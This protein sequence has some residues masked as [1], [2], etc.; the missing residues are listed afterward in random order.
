M[1]KSNS[2]TFGAVFSISSPAI[3]EP[4]LDLNLVIDE[5]DGTV[6]GFAHLVGPNPA[7]ADKIKYSVWGSFKLVQVPGS[8][9][10]AIH[11]SGT[12]TQKLNWP[13][14]G[15]IGP[16]ILPS[17][18]FSMVLPVDWSTGQGSFFAVVDKTTWGGSGV[19]QREYPAA[20]A[21]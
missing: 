3:V 12:G 8:D 4:A 17:M 18:K 5:A 7:G 6:T 11:V 21:A 19:A 9:E 2:K 1:A 15:G 16:V 10:K 20:V 13:I 14:H